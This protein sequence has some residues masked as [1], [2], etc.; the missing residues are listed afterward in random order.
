MDSGFDQLMHPPDEI[1]LR[2]AAKQAAVFVNEICRGMLG[3]GVR[4]PV[5]HG[6]PIPS[7]AGSGGNVI[8]NRHEISACAGCQEIRNLIPGFVIQFLVGIEHQHPVSLHECEGGI[9]GPGEVIFPGDGNYGGAKLVGNIGAVV[10]RAGV[11]DHNLTDHSGHTLEAMSQ[12]LRPVLHD[13]RETD[14]RHAFLIKR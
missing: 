4:V 12:A 1:N 11:G 14:S 6:D 3:A 2:V 8:A 9:A 7:P 10:S 13:H 5:R